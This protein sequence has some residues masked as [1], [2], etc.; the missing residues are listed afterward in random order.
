MGSETSFLL[1]LLKDNYEI[2]YSPT[3]VIGHR[4][5]PNALKLSTICLRGFRSGRGE[6]H[7][8][9]LPR[10]ALLKKNPTLWHLYCGVSIIWYGA[11]MIGSIMFSNKKLRCHNFVRTIRGIGIRLEAF[12]IAKQYLA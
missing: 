2:V 10:E 3:V 1:G 11:K 6:A 5:Q 12:R 4:V 9:G 8:L 7:C